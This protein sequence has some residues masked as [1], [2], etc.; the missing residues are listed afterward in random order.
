MAP[1]K[2]EKMGIWGSDGKRPEDR[3]VGTIAQQ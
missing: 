2:H 3:D 1:N